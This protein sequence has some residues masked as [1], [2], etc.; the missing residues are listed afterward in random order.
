[1]QKI[2]HSCLSRELKNRRNNEKIEEYDFPSYGICGYEAELICGTIKV[3]VQ[4][5]LDC[6][7]E[8]CD[9]IKQSKDPYNL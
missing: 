5:Q 7:K 6:T 2:L 1:M 8:I 4:V 9:A 3:L